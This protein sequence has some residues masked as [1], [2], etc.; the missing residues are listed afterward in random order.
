MDF[1]W[2]Q[3]FMKARRTLHDPSTS[4]STFLFTFHHMNR[5]RRVPR[6]ACEHKATLEVEKF[7]RF[8]WHTFS[9]HFSVFWKN[10]PHPSVLREPVLSTNCKIVEFCGQ[11]VQLVSESS[12]NLCL[13]V[14]LRWLM[15]KLVEKC[16][17]SPITEA[18]RKCQWLCPIK[19]K[20]LSQI[21][22]HRFE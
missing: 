22:S 12:R 9:S 10:F 1:N 3:A 14:E 20:N 15:R 5:L 4:I 13:S 17:F 8:L 6:C 7:Y 16:E 21:E 11:S 18:F 19:N 2:F